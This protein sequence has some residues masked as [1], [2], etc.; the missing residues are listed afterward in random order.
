[1]TDFKLA[2]VTQRNLMPHGVA[3]VTPDFPSTKFWT[4]TGM[5]P[6][7]E[8]GQ[9]VTLEGELVVFDGDPL[10]TGQTL[11]GT[12]ETYWH[13][14]EE[15]LGLSLLKAGSTP[16][17]TLSAGRYAKVRSRV[18][19]VSTRDGV[20]AN[21]ARH[22]LPFE[23]TYVE[24]NGTVVMST[25]TGN[26]NWPIGIDALIDAAHQVCG[27]VFNGVYDGMAFESRILP[28]EEGRVSAQELL[29]VLRDLP[30][31]GQ[32]EIMSQAGELLGALTYLEL[33]GHAWM[34]QLA[35][36]VGH[37]QS[38]SDRVRMLDPH[39]SDGASQ[40]ITEPDTRETEISMSEIAVAVD[41]GQDERES[42]VRAV[43]RD[44]ATARLHL[45]DNSP[46][47]DEDL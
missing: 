8:R 42:W 38:V 43:T 22:L 44:G 14:A 25:S 4:P 34:G 27:Y 12:Y 23:R 29:D 35:M 16:I 2:T 33:E 15:H 30:E 10:F 37:G 41:L 13:S 47:P 21:E 20:D 46:L 24:R 32:V 40:T 1:M 39:A 3:F 17:G 5:Y 9:D 28:G 36:E 6:T 18:F 45:R 31:D 26:G 11:E 7:V 19:S